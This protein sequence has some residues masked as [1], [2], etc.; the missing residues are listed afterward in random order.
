MEMICMVIKLCAVHGD[1][2]YLARWLCGRVLNHACMFLLLLQ[3]EVV[4]KDHGRTS[5]TSLPSPV[6]IDIIK[7][8]NPPVFSQS[9]YTAAFNEDEAVGYT[10]IRIS[11]SD[12]DTEV[13]GLVVFFVCQCGKLVDW[14]VSFFES[15]LW[16]GEV[17]N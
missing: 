13:S 5:L 15:V 4:A 17:L 6:V 1:T 2:C 9:Q 16:L 12:A 10:V 7:N 3:F 8:Q 14:W 11:A